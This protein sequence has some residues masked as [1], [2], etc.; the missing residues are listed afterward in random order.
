MNITALD[1][2]DPI[3]AACRLNVYLTEIEQ[4]GHQKHIRIVYPPDWGPYILQHWFPVIRS[5]GFRVTIIL[6]QERTP[7][8]NVAAWLTVGIPPIRDLIDGAELMNEPSSTSQMGPHEYALWH[9][10]LLP[11]VRQALP[12]VPVLSPTINFGKGWETWLRRTGLT[13]A[14]GD[15]DIMSIHPQGGS[16]AEMRQITQMVGSHRVWA[17][18]SFWTE[19]SKLRALG[20]NVERTYV[21]TWNPDPQ[22]PEQVWR[23]GGMTPPC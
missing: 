9:R 10:A 1:L 17:T 21:Y 14:A 15:Y 20:V 5:H 2:T 11:L 4:A 8:T 19:P 13:V 6:A 22:H 23:P 18:E 3:T 16:Q 7:V 12:G